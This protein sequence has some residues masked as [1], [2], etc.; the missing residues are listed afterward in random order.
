MGVDTQ[1]G[2]SY[3]DVFDT[4]PYVPD[5]QTCQMNC[6]EDRRCKFFLYDTTNEICKLMS[7]SERTCKK[8]RG[9]PEIKLDGCPKVSIKTLS[10]PSDFG[11]TCPPPSKLYTNMLGVEHCC[12]SPFCCFD[13]CNRTVPD[14]KCLENVP[15]SQWRKQGNYWEAIQYDS[16]TTKTLTREMAIRAAQTIRVAPPMFNARNCCPLH[17]TSCPPGQERCPPIWVRGK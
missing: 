2:C 1:I 12:C 3:H 8:R 13:K 4:T 15:N 17:Q 6:L 14:F 11:G 7:S 5:L 9:P 10:T 16:A